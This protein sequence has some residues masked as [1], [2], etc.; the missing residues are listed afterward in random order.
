[1]IIAAMAGLAMI[2]LAG[3]AGFL[4]R[5]IRR[6]TAQ[7]MALAEERSRL[8]T[9]IAL[10]QEIERQLRAAQQT[11]RDAVDSISEG[12]VIYDRDDCFVMCNDPHRRL[13]PDGARLMVPGTR[14]EEIVWAS[15]DAGWYADAVGCEP[16]WLADR[17]H[18]HDHPSAPISNGSPTADA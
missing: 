4:I 17:M 5:E 14:F 3:L 10:R 15:L 8:Q 9:D 12:F 16:E 6:R 2:L 11:L 13:Y 1:M 7:E 18:A